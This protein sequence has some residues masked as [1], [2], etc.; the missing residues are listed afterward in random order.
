MAEFKL[1]AT[2]IILG[3]TEAV[4]YFIFFRCNLIDNIFFFMNLIFILWYIVMF[5][6]WFSYVKPRQQV[7]KTLPLRHIMFLELKKHN[8]VA[9]TARLIEKKEWGSGLNWPRLALAALAKVS[10]L[11]AALM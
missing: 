11:N 3:G 1:K 9:G 7:S 8:G 10:S 2:S 6:L 5:L 4:P